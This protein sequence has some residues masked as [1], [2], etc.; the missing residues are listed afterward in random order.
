MCVAGPD[1]DGDDAIGPGE[2]TGRKVG[3]LEEYVDNLLVKI[4]ENTSVLLENNLE[5]F[6]YQDQ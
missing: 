3:D 5:S 4:M 6:S 1:R 2:G